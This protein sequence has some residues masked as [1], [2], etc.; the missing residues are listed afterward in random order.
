MKGK[1]KK[2]FELI[3][4]FGIKTTIYQFVCATVFKNNTKLGQYLD[5]KKHENVK[6][7]LVLNY[8]EVLNKYKNYEVG[9][10]N[11]IG[12]NKIVWLLWWQGI[13]NAPDIVKLAVKSMIEQ[14]EGYDIVV[15]DK[16]NY[17]NYISLPDNIIDKLNNESMTLTHFSDILRMVLLAEYGGVWVDATLLCTKGLDKLNMD[18]YKFY[19]IKHELYSDWH[20]CKGLWT[21]FFMATGKNNPMFYFFR[22][23]FYKYWENENSLICYFLID[24]IMS[25]GYEHIPFISEQ[26]DNVPKNNSNVF[27]LQNIL[28]EEFNSITWCDLLKKCSLHKLNYKM[29]LRIKSSN[30]NNTFYGY[31]FNKY[32]K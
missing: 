32:N 25:I 14:N 10:I 19:T 2:Y 1:I 20:V 22:D 8:E 13:D 7:Y 5:R 9:N 24:C 3:N 6:K 27:E 26:I 16:N 18:S 31:L 23:M 28:N 17:S 4:N 30:K 12:D 29:N 21:G 15:I 11:V